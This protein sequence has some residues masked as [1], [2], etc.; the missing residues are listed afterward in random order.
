MLIRRSSWLDVLCLRQGKV[1]SK[2][3]NDD[4]RPEEPWTGKPL[5]P[6]RMNGTGGVWPAGAEQCIHY[7]SLYR[8]VPYYRTVTTLYRLTKTEG[9]KRRALPLTQQTSH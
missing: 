2:T 9:W 4:T 3:E 1:K 7:P 8:L 5:R 6:P